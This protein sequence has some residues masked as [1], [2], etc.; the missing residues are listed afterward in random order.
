MY[1]NNREPGMFKRNNNVIIL[2]V[3]Y[4]FLCCAPAMAYF[5]FGV[6]NY[7]LQLLFGF[8]AALLLSYKNIFA[9]KIGREKAHLEK[10]L[11]CPKDD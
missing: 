1:P 3:S 7:M 4:Y 11:D 8:G 5:D 6:C 9:K 10:E 2:T